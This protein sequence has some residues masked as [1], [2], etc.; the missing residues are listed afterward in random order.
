MPFPEGVMSLPEIAVLLKT[1]LG[2]AGKLGSTKRQ[3]DWK[4]RVSAHFNPIAKNIAPMLSRYRDA[5][6]QKAK[7]L[8]GWRPVTNEESILATAERLLRFNLNK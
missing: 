8:L 2:D 5:N 4:A 6:N 3:A 1:R 7:E